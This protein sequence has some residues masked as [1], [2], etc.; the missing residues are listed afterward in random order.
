MRR[1]LLSAVELINLPFQAESLER[2][3]DGLVAVPV[4]SGLGQ[5]V[6]KVRYP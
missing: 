6:G 2:S 5:P 1:K 4:P 3:S